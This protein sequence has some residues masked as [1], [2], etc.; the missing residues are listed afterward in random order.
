VS[1]T[2][3]DFDFFPLIS[4]SIWTG[5]KAAFLKKGMTYFHLPTNEEDTFECNN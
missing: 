4:F 1:A 2:V 3:Y 5:G